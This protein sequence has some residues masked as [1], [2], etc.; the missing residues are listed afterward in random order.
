MTLC[1]DELYYAFYDEDKD[2]LKT[3]YH[4]HSFTAN[5][6]ACAVANEN[7]AI[8][9]E[10]NMEEYLKPKI[11]AFKRGLEKFR[12]YPHVGDIRQCR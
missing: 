12:D 7:L 1:T 8:L 5:P 6:L 10:M 11:L 2:G 9:Q 3:F 4:G